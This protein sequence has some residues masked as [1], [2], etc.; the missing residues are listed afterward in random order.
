[1]GKLGIPNIYELF[2]YQTVN[3]IFKVKNNTM[4]EAFPTKFQI[5]QHKYATRH[6]KIIL[7]TRNNLQG[8]RV[9]Y[10]LTWTSSLE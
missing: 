8:S 7:K 3:L 5:L 6:R 1:M 2:V 10:I 9:C 4:P